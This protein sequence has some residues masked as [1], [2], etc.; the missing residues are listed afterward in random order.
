MKLCQKLNRLRPEK[1]ER[2]PTNLFDQI[3]KIK[4]PFYHV[5]S[6]VSDIELIAIMITNAPSEYELVMT[7]KQ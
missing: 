6:D 5:A 2:N 3:D 4:N 1:G 7:G